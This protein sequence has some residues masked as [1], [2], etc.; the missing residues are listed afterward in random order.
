MTRARDVADTQDNLGGAVPPVVA[1]KNAV[2]NG[3]FD[4]WQRGT[5]FTNP[6][7]GQTFTTDRWSAYFG[8]TGTV[9]QDTSLVNANSRY[10]LRMTASA[11]ATYSLLSIIETMNV[12]PLIGKTITLSGYYAGTA[13]L[14]PGVALN[15]STTVDDS[16]Y[17]INTSATLIGGSIPT[18][19][20]SFQRFSVTFS[21]SSTARTLRIALDVPMVNTNFITFSNLQLEVGSVATPFSRAGG[22][23]Q[24]ELA[25]CQRYYYRA[26]TSQNYGQL[27]IGGIATSTTNV[28]FSLLAP[29][30]LRTTPSSVDFST[31]GVFDCNTNRYTITNV[32]LNTNQSTPSIVHAS[33]SIASGGVTLRYYVLSANNS[34]SGYLGFSAEL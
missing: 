33:A 3:G 1:G 28:D 9:T 20:G 15:Y 11:S 26:T 8:G 17:N 14:L 21:L 6:G 2:I 13:G 30:T 25:A 19:T 27:F 12:L 18:S 22:T 31:I 4:I 16:I 29:V 24:G 23:I 34:T 10:G 7:A 32:T 5:T